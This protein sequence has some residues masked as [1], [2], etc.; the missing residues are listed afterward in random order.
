MSSDPALAIATLAAAILRV[1]GSA[2]PEDVVVAVDDAINAFP[3]GIF[4]SAGRKTAP[5]EMVPPRKNS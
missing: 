4:P 3:P 5:N 2:T 1:R